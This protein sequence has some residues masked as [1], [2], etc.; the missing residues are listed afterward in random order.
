MKH[1]NRFVD[2]SVNEAIGVA[3]PTTFYVKYLTHMVIDELYENIDNN[4]GSDNFEG[5]DSVDIV[6][7]Y[8]DIKN[9]LPRGKKQIEEYLKFPLSEI[10]LKVEFNRE[11]YY[12]YPD[13]YKYEIGGYSSPFARGRESEATRFKPSIKQDVDHTISVHLC[14]EIWYNDRFKKIG[15]ELYQFENT[16]LFKKIEGVIMHEFNHLYEIYNRKIGGRPPMQLALSWATLKDIYKDVPFYLYNFWSNNFTDFIYMSEP[17]EINAHTQEAKSYIDRMGFEAFKENKLWK[18]AKKMQNW[19]YKEF[20]N[21]FNIIAK[22]RGL[23][24]TIDK[25]KEDFVDEFW[26][27]SIDFG[28]YPKISPEKLSRMSTDK[29]FELFQRRIRDAGEKYIRN[30]GRLYANK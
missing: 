20:V 29:F 9:L 11:M 10:I 18:D 28:E 17:Y 8:N 12:E 16:H 21:R 24:V 23:D 19:D 14:I 26:N 25:M 13:G 27:L 30:F 2:F 4:R 6:L 1:I 15:K 5:S 7:N 3:V 22:Q